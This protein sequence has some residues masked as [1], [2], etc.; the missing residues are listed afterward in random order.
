LFPDLLQENFEPALQVGK[1]HLVGVGDAD[2]P[3]TGGGKVE[4][5]RRPEPARADGF[6]S[7]DSGGLLQPAN[8]YYKIE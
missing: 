6:S 5:R 2:S 1:L 7:T 8:F 3:H 4:L